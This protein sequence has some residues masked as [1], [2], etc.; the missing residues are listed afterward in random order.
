MLE[1]LA[2]GF[3]L[4]YMKGV[5]LCLEYLQLQMLLGPTVT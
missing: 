3:P 2:V 5:C 4:K 1:R